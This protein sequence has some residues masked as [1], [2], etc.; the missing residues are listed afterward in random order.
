MTLGAAASK[1]GP[2]AQTDAPSHR[3]P[4]TRSLFFMTLKRPKKTLYVNHVPGRFPFSWF[5]FYSVL[6]PDSLN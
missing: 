1:G 4:R 3:D 2:D 6:L 5:V